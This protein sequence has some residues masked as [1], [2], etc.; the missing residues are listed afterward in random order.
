MNA[1]CSVNKYFILLI[2]A[3][4]A[5]EIVDNSHIGNAT[6][7]NSSGLIAINNAPMIPAADPINSNATFIPSA[8]QTYDIAIYGNILPQNSDH[9]MLPNNVELSCRRNCVLLQNR[10]EY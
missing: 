5:S 3:N 8:L 2:C 1:N 10:R 7:A 9:G 6:L 4:T